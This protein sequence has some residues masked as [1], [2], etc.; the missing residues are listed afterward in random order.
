MH[1]HLK[2]PIQKVL[3]VNKPYKQI[4]DQDRYIIIGASEFLLN[5]IGK[6]I[7]NDLPGTEVSQNIN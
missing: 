7:L 2:D 6:E 3:V 4:R 1:S 5:F